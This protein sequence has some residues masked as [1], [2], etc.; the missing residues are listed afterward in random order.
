MTMS[1][2]SDDSSQESAENHHRRGK[3]VKRK[4]ALWKRILLR[5]STWVGIGAIVVALAV[6]YYLLRHIDAHKPE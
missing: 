1:G 3:W 2:L 5:K 4:R 6:L